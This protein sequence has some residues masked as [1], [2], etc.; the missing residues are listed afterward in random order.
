M[1]NRRS[2][3]L[4]LGIALGA[5]TGTAIGVAT[6]HAPHPPQRKL[7]PFDDAAPGLIGLETALSLGL[8]AVAAGRLELAT[9]VAALSIR[10]AEIIGERRSLAPGQ[11]ADLVLFDPDARWRVEASALASASSNTPLLGMELPGVVRMTIADG[12][13]TYRA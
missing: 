10:P 8:S 3:L 2:G 5:G 7:V 9:L 6:D 13:V 12:R 4:G 11:A 1:T